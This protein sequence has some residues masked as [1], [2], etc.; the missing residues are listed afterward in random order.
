MNPDYQPHNV[1]SYVYS[2]KIHKSH[3]LR[4]RNEK[5]IDLIQKQFT[6]PMRTDTT[7][8]EEIYMR[9]REMINKKDEKMMED[10]TKTRKQKEMEVKFYQDQ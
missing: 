5:M 3:A 4:E 1:F 9:D 10:R 7:K 2:T 8:E 6:S